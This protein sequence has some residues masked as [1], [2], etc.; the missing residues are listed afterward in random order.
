M[1]NSE[2]RTLCQK[3]LEKFQSSL[4]SRKQGKSLDFDEKTEGFK[5]YKL[6]KRKIN[7]RESKIRS[8]HTR[9]ARCKGKDS[10]CCYWWDVWSDSDGAHGEEVEKKKERKVNYIRFLRWTPSGNFRLWCWGNNIWFAS[11]LESN[12][13]L[14]NFI[15]LKKFHHSIKI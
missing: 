6:L 4:N 13:R 3:H 7:W 9:A 12:W 5:R 1:A 10:S 14:R 2:S 11:L 15:T 8:I